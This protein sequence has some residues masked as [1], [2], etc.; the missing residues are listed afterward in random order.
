MA[1]YL[2]FPYTPLW[3]GQGQF[4]RWD[5]RSSGKLHSVDWYLVTDVS[6][7]RIDPIFKG[8][9]VQEQ[10]NGSQWILSY[11][12]VGIRIIRPTTTASKIHVS[13]CVFNSSQG[14]KY[15][16]GNGDIMPRTLNLSSR[17]SYVVSFVSRPL[18][19]RYIDASTC[20]LWLCLVKKPVS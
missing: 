8:P 16:W 2:H 14:R 19:S 6:G 12:T 3:E 11:S 5:R 4:Y 9:V 15:V 18:Y 7:P 1:L 10:W 13:A 17:L 20:E